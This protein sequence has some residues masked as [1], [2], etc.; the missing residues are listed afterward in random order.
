[1]QVAARDEVGKTGKAGMEEA[2][3]CTFKLSQGQ[4]EG[5]LE[6]GCGFG[7]LWGV[8]GFRASFRF[9]VF[10]G[11]VHDSLPACACFVWMI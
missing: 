11:R 7:V 2:C 8:L 5:F 3:F 4:G 1:M 10:G 6:F 9:R